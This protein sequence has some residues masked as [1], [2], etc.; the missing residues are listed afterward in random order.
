MN[1]INPISS[2]RHC[3]SMEVLD[4]AWIVKKSAKILDYDQ[5]PEKNSSL[6]HKMCAL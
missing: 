1:Q 4:G 3:Q 2:I 5:I 6:F